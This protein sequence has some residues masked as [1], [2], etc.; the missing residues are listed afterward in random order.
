M[1]PMLMAT[2]PRRRKPKDGAEIDKEDCFFVLP[3]PPTSTFDFLDNIPGWDV[4]EELSFKELP[5]FTSDE[6]L[7]LRGI[8]IRQ[9]VSCGSINFESDYK[10]E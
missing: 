8:P 4:N 7:E 3:S 5:S 10:N 1:F 2:I 6:I 9:T